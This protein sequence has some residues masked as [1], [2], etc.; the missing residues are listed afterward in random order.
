MPGLACQATAPLMREAAGAQGS[1]DD[2]RLPHRRVPPR[3]TARG[4]RAVGSR[5]PQ[6]ALSG[7]GNVE[8]P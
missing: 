8:P 3:F 4:E 1:Q 2:A 6:M 7:R 5:A